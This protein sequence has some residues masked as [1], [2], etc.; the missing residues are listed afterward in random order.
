MK[1]TRK[2]IQFILLA[3]LVIAGAGA[4]FYYLEWQKPRIVLE[5]AFDTIGKSRDVTIT[6]SDS[7]SGI[8][9]YSVAVIQG[10]QKVVV[11][12]E[13]LPF[14]GTLE[15]R[16]EL[17][18]VPRDLRIK[19]G[20]ADFLVKVVDFS[21]LRNTATYEAK[22][23]VDSVPPRVALLTS[24]HNINP[25]GTCLVVYRTSKPVVSGGVKCANEFFPGYLVQGSTRP[26]YVCYFA[27]PRDVTRTTPMA[28][29]VADRA[30]N[31]TSTG[32]PFYIRST[33]PFRSDTVTVGDTFVQQKAV[34]F[35]EQ[36]TTLAGKSSTDVFAY[37]NSSMRADND[38]KIRS[39]CAKSDGKQLWQGIFLRMKNSAPKALFGDERTYVYQGASLG[40]SV[41]LGVDLASLAQSP[42]EA[43]NA[44]TVIFAEFLG[45]YGNCVI[46]DHGQGISSLYAHLSSI[47]VKVGDRVSKEQVIGNSGATGF[48]GGDHLHFSILVGGVFVDPKEWWDPHWIKDNV[49]AKIQFASTL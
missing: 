28:V 26:Y 11:A 14:K 46:I 47:A 21:P 9:S 24:A 25:G 38:N 37:V 36:D 32:I 48:A 30:G 6:L 40:T 12:Q 22:I 13:D 23:S 19:D 49:E 8:R 44:G 15:K 39:V 35:Q 10:G 45:I 20:E 18:I 16:L 33:R 41:H 4:T 27:I 17:K 43:A 7:R 29:T 3:I 5:K 34:E 2:T 1:G 31:Q 42:V